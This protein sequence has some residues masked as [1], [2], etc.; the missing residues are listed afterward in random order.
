M[1]ENKLI[2]RDIK[3]ENIIFSDERDNFKLKLIDYGLATYT[4][5][6]NYRFPKCG[7]P[8]YAAP[9]I[10]NLKD[11]KY[12]YSNACDIFSLGSVFWKLLVRKDLFLGKTQEEILI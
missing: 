10:V 9:E 7:T 3:P 5:V 6:P 8:G 12:K 1:H 4:D 11:L 2:H